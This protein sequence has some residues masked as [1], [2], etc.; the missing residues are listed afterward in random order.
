MTQMDFNFT[1]GGTAAGTSCVTTQRDRLA[2]SDRSLDLIGGTP[3]DVALTLH[4]DAVARSGS[5]PDCT[6][7]VC[8]GVTRRCV[9]VQ[10]LPHSRCQIIL[11]GRIQTLNRQVV[12]RDGESPR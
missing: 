2:L 3:D 12:T 10:E 1:G 8:D 11:G 4:N 5:A 9:F 6:L 7:S